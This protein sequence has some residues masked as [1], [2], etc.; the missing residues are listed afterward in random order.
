MYWRKCI[1]PIWKS[2]VWGNEV[3]NTVC[4]IQ[5]VQVSFLCHTKVLS[6]TLKVTFSSVKQMKYRLAT[7]RQSLLSYPLQ[8]AMSSDLLAGLDFFFGQAPGMRGQLDKTDTWDERW[9]ERG[10]RGRRTE[11][12]LDLEFSL[13]WSSQHNDTC[14]TATSTCSFNLQLWLDKMLL[15]V[16][17][18]NFTA[19]CIYFRMQ[20][21]LQKMFNIHA[22]IR[23]FNKWLCHFYITRSSKQNNDIIKQVFWT[24][25]PVWHQKDSMLNSHHWPSYCCGVGLIRIPKQTR[26][27]FIAPQ[28]HTDCDFREIQKDVLMYLHFKW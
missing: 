14:L 10:G 18:Y 16:I 8:R 26:Q 23:T 13:P 11:S 9:R 25:S 22:N 20:D 15:L 17:R 27:C 19:V 5:P 6:G 2:I 21:G 7:N 3:R 4:T 24:L 28:S 1:E 12:W